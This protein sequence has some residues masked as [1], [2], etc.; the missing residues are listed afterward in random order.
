MSEVCLL[1]VIV[2]DLFDC[3]SEFSLKVPRNNQPKSKRTFE[4][5]QSQKESL[6]MQRCVISRKDSLDAA[7]TSFAEKIVVKSTISANDLLF[8][9][10]L[11]YQYTNSCF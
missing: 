9:V 3:V 5:M 11:R 7:S 10:S 4:T 6:T 8:Q 1:Y 2:D